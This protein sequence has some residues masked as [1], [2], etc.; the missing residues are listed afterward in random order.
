MFKELAHIDWLVFSWVNAGLSS[1]VLDETMPLV[2]YLGVWWLGTGILVAIVLWQRSRASLLAGLAYGVAGGASIVLKMAV[3]RP[4]PALLPG[5]IV[6]YRPPAG[7]E[8]G[9]L[10]WAHT[11]FPSG[12]TIAVFAGATLIAHY[13]PRYRAVAYGVA[14]TVGFSRVYLGVHYPTDVLTSVVLG[15]GLTKLILGSKLLR[16]KILGEEETGDQPRS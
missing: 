3:A 6:R 12:H 16:R 2:S 11:S 9:L 10:P 7:V 5:A 8:D 4:R 14:A 15:I 1:R 13:W